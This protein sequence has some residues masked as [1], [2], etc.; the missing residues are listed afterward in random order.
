MGAACMRRTHYCYYYCCRN[1]CL[2][3]FDRTAFHAITASIVLS[4]L[5]MFL[6][7]ASCSRPRLQ[8]MLLLRDVAQC[9]LNYIQLMMCACVWF[10]HA[11]VDTPS[12][13][14]NDVT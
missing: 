14:P 8:R 9:D 11:D 4:L 3:F 13:H 12:H 7:G 5:L 6:I 2:G 1:D 10:L